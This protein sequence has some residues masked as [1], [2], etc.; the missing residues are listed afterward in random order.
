MCSDPF[1]YQLRRPSDDLLGLG[2]I[3]GQ[4]ENCF[5]GY[6]SMKTNSNSHVLS[7]Y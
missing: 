7:L 5:N 3:I 4:F 2:V 6:A 1:N